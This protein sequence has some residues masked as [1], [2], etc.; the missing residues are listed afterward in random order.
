MLKQ[1]VEFSF[2]FCPELSVESKQIYLKNLEKHSY[3]PLDVSIFMIKFSKLVVSFI[4]ETCMND[5]CNDRKSPHRIASKKIH[6]FSAVN[7]VFFEHNFDFHLIALINT[8]TFFLSY[9]L[10]P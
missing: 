10:A 6:Y 8:T 5:F 3:F 4:R 1:N 2:L 9:N 7:F